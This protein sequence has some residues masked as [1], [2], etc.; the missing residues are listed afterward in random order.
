MINHEKI[1]IIIPVFNAEKYLE[2]CLSTVL[3]QTYKNIEIIVV[4]DGSTDNSAAILK[5]YPQLIYHY[6]ENSGQGI[7]RN[8]G[9]QLATSD[10]IVFV[11]ADDYVDEFLLEKLMDKMTVNVSIVSC[12][13][14]RLVGNK[15]I[16]DQFS[17]SGL[18]SNKEAMVTMNPAACNKLYRKAIF[19]EKKFIEQRLRY[20]DTA[21]FPDFLSVAKE[22]YMID[23]SLYYYRIYENS[24]MRKWDNKIDD[25]F[26]IAKY[27]LNSSSYTEYK[28]E[29]DYIVFK[30]VVF[31]HLSRIIHFDK[32]TIKKG[33]EDSRKFILNNISDYNSNQYIKKDKQWWFFMG[34]RLFR[35]NLLGLSTSLLKIVEKYIPR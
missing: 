5:Q 11:D 1:S 26:E 12:G 15:Q 24:T 14:T 10:F 25:I 7:A 27:I 19:N 8:I 33:L 35:M 13:M 28:Q 18:L 32:A 20:E 3:N 31:G 30:H 34:Y 4:D 9:I 22:V 16:E 21:S 2:K 29:Y 23:E 6:Q 17:K